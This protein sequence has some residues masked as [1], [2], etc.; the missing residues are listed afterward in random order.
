M[1]L[2]IILLMAKHFYFM[3][4]IW[5]NKSKIRKEISPDLWGIIKPRIKRMEFNSS[6]FNEKFVQG[7]SWKS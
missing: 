7:L 5:K 2:W 3:K 1:E 4:K 6:K